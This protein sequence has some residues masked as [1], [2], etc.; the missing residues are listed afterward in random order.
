M[1]MESNIRRVAKRGTFKDATAHVTTFAPEF[2]ISP[3][4]YMQDPRT[5]RLTLASSGKHVLGI[6]Y[7]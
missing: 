3:K 2:P 7:R 6:A 4:K 5:D 1:M